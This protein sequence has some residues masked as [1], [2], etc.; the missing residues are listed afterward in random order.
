MYLDVAICPE[1]NRELALNTSKCRHCGRDISEL[2]YK[3]VFRWSLVDRFVLLSLT[4]LM[5]CFFVPWFPGEF[6]FRETP[7]SIY[8][9]LTHIVDLEIDFLDSYNI[10]R[11]GLVLPLFALV[12]FFMVYFE[13]TLKSSPF[14]GIFLFVILSTVGILKAQRGCLVFYCLSCLG[15]FYCFCPGFS[16]TIY[17]GDSWPSGSPIP[18][19]IFCP[20]DIDLSC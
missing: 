10:L 13:E 15:Y 9:L 16:A 14:P 3:S 8:T 4:T 2:K 20:Y 11:M 6:L 12:L 5:A 7:F 17:K 1:C 19:W 18:L